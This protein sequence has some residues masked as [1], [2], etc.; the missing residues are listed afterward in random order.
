MGQTE[1]VAARNRCS[2]F[3][4]RLKLIHFKLKMKP[5]FLYDFDNE[6]TNFL[7]ADKDFV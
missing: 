6:D 2:E 4:K 5:F 3:F 1:A 7:D